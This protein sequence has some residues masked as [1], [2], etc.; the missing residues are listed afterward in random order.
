MEETEEIT[1]KEVKLSDNPLQFLEKDSEKLINKI[2]ELVEKAKNGDPDA[3]VKLGYFYMEGKYFEKNEKKAVELFKKAAEKDNLDAII[4]LSICYENGFGVEENEEKA[5]NYFIQA[6][7]M[8]DV[9]S[10]YYL[11]GFYKEINFVGK[12]ITKTIKLYE[13]AFYFGNSYLHGI[14]GVEQNLEEGIKLPKTAAKN[15]NHKAMFELGYCYHYGYGDIEQN[16]EKAIEFYNKAAEYYNSEAMF[17]LGICYEFYKENKKEAIRLYKKSA[18]LNN[19]KAKS[20]LEI[21][22]YEEIEDKTVNDKFETPERKIPT[23]TQEFSKTSNITDVDNIENEYFENLV[24]QQEK[25]KQEDKQSQ[26]ID[27]K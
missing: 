5:C 3:M 7:D 26:G 18:N 9:D 27:V 22:Q 1:E 15:G 25:S 10:L 24:D 16:L 14:N 17:Y 19:Y 12:D 13:K 4:N 21:M 2:S 6:V 8:C 11:I 23:T 20:R